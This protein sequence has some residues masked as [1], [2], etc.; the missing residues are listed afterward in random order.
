MEKYE[1]CDTPPSPQYDMYT[2]E[3]I[4]TIF[5]LFHPSQSYRYSPNDMSTR[6][7]PGWKSQVLHAEPD[8]QVRQNAV[9][10]YFNLRQAYAQNS[11]LHP[12]ETLRNLP[13]HRRTI[14]GYNLA[15]KRRL[16][17]RTPD[18]Q[19]LNRTRPSV[20]RRS[21]ENGNGRK[22][23]APR[24]AILQPSYESDQEMYPGPII[25][26]TPTRRHSETPVIH[27]DPGLP[28]KVPQV[29][30]R[31]PRLPPKDQQIIHRDPLLSIKAQQIIHRGPQS[32][33][34]ISHVIPNNHSVD[35]NRTHFLPKYP[36]PGHPTSSNKV[37]QNIV[38]HEEPDAHF[39]RSRN[40]RIYYEDPKKRASDFPVDDVIPNTAI[41]NDEDLTRPNT[42]RNV[43]TGPRN[44]KT[45][46]ASSPSLTMNSEGM[47]EDTSI[48]KPPT[49][50]NEEIPVTNSN[51]TRFLDENTVSEATNTAKPDQKHSENLQNGKKDKKYKFCCFYCKKK[52]RWF[53]HWQAHERI[54]TGVRPYKCTQ[55]ERCFT[56][57]DGLQ[58]HMVIHSTKQAHKCSSCSK[59][60]SR[61]AMLDRHILE[62]TGIIPYKCE[63][64]DVEVLDP[65]TIEEHL[66]KHP[67]Q[68]KFACQYCKRCFLNGRRLVRHIRAHTGEK[69]F[70]CAQCKMRFS[71]KSA[72]LIHHRVHSGVKPFRCPD[73]GKA[74]SISGN[75]RRHLLIHTGER[76]FPCTKCK[77]KFNNKSHLARHLSTQH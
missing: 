28:P 37:I 52:F 1:K 63:I 77:R 23:S 19:E 65:E 57:G 56:R 29:I 25:P 53:S 68:K 26:F 17:S 34:S 54:H 38:V 36:E 73:C 66:N 61:K 18:Y 43:K 15:H 48:P 31:G 24:E 62:H 39:I 9:R 22:F 55:C 64:C 20:I 12:F 58:A 35:H 3:Y 60:F 40:T 71:K 4:R 30:Q 47:Q 72:L 70:P 11:S 74:F 5:S 50:L 46:D 33:H 14:R 42:G 41:D 76:P 51:S 16:Q 67:G 32:E 27:N 6:Y 45:G 8:F 7:F 21:I 59:V 10:N 49:Q 13:R 44:V 2:A 69:P 75:L